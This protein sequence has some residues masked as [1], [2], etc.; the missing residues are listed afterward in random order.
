M[1]NWTT[2]IDP[3][4]TRQYGVEEL[5]N[6][7]FE[8]PGWPGKGPTVNL[9]IPECELH[10]VFFDGNTP[11]ALVNR[12]TKNKNVKNWTSLRLRGGNQSQCVSDAVL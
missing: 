7:C 2:R 12:P 9:L 8:P 1:T 6:V 10:F 4:L 3:S 11:V 5:H